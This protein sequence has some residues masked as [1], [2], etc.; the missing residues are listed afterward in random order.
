[1]VDDSSH[2]EGDKH[3]YSC[4]DN[5]NSSHSCNYSRDELEL[6]AAAIRRVSVE[7]RRRSSVGVGVGVGMKGVH[8][9][10]LSVND[11]MAVDMGV[12][13]ECQW[14]HLQ[15]LER[16]VVRLQRELEAYQAREQGSSVGVSESEQELVAARPTVPSPMPDSTTSTT[17]T[18]VTAAISVTDTV[19]ILHQE[20]AVR[21]NEREQE[22][23]EVL[24]LVLKDDEKEESV[25]VEEGVK[26]EE[27][28]QCR[29]VVDA[30]AV[31][32][33]AVRERRQQ[34][35]QHITHMSQHIAHQNLSMHVE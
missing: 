25:E 1:M 6:A 24:A 5:Y 32:M 26:E 10:D 31:M 28:V 30:L 33:E 22:T 12:M 34:R 3:Q 7:T 29:E 21:P 13:E 27:I 18:T 2:M 11:S 35:Q 8:G 23:G 14:S 16:E 9:M 20:M 4:S 17:T 19:T 15:H